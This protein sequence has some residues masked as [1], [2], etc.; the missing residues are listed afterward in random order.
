MTPL[1]PHL[2]AF[3][4]QRLPIERRASSHT[5]ASYAYAFKLLLQYASDRLHVPPSA[6]HLEQIDAVLVVAFL[7]HL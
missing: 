6:L 3:F 2:S 4:Q 5:S 7:N 1:A